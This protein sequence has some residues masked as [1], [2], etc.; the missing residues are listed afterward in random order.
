VISME[1]TVNVVMRI[2]LMLDPEV[3]ISTVSN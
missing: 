3:S 2:L 1:V